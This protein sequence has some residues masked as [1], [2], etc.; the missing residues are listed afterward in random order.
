MSIDTSYNKYI[1][2]VVVAVVVVVVVV[3]VVAVV[4][5]V[6]VAAEAVSSC[7][8]RSVQNMFRPIAPASGKIVERMWAE[9]ARR[10]ASQRCL[11]AECTAYPARVVEAQSG[12]AART[13]REKRRRP[14]GS[15]PS[16]D[17]PTDYLTGK[18]SGNTC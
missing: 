15:P 5:V 3:V 17:T 12:S 6:V 9:T 11:P 14:L 4:V 18:L 7:G 16:A 2:V 13:R 1:L 10:S 8:R